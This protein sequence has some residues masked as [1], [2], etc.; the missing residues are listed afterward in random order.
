MN[1][2]LT[3]L[4]RAAL[5]LIANTPGIYLGRFTERL[6]PGRGHA[7]KAR[8]TAQ[9]ATRWGGG[10]TEPL[11]K[12]GLVRKDRFVDCGGARLYLTDAGAAVLEQQA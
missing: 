4:Q 9:G 6:L 7:G 11:V 1:V 3:P 10:Y 5:R 2:K 12:A 8:W